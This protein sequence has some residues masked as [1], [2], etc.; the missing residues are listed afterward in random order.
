VSNNS[1]MAADAWD[2][3]SLDELAEDAVPCTNMDHL[4][5][6]DMT[7]TQ[8]AYCNHCRIE[9]TQIGDEYPHVA[10]ATDAQVASLPTRLQQWAEQFRPDGALRDSTK[11]T[12]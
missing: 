2:V 1:A 8:L 10:D 7:A 5:N 3:P 11:H 9:Q 4:H 6:Y 12:G